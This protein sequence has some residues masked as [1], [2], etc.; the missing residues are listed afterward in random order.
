LFP[1]A[2]IDDI[3]AGFYVKEDG[4]VNPVDVTMA[5][6]KGARMRGVRIIEGTPVTGVL[7]QRGHVTGICTASG[8]IKTD[9]V[10][11]CTGMWTR[12]FGALAGVNIVNQAAEH[13]YL[14]H[15]PIKD[16]PKMPV[17]EDPGAYG[18][19]REEGGGLLV[20]L[21]EPTCA[22]WRVEGIPEDFSFGE[23]PPD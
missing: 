7:Q 15:E 5:L 20:G 17:L 14:T 22:P 12:T 2:R 16:L 9:I 8:D 10:V 18:Y 1:L 6:A 4:R 3:E 11:N 21:F 23:L 19:Y 13:Y